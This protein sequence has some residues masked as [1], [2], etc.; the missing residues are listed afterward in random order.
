[1]CI[2]CQENCSCCPKAGGMDIKYLLKTPVPR[3]WDIFNT[4]SNTSPSSDG[5][6]SLSNMGSYL[7]GMEP[8]QVTHNFFWKA[9][10]I[11]ISDT[12]RNIIQKRKMRNKNGS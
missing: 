4:V 9:M 6:V 7:I 11:F 2:S 5:L 3:L 12:N 1:M 8:I 10:N